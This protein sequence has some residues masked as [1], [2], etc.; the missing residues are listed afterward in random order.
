MKIIH[1]ADIHLSSKMTAFLTEK[2]ASERREEITGTFFNLVEFA[3]QNEVRAII[4]AG[5]FF[6]SADFVQSSTVKRINFIISSAPKID[7][8]YLRGN[9]DE[10]TTFLDEKNLPN[11]KTFSYKNWKKYSYQEKNQIVDI[12]GLETKTSIPDE[13]YNSLKP[14]KSHLNIAILHGQTASYRTKD[15]AAEISLP[16][17]QMKNLDYLAL[18]HI[19]EF[20]IEKLDNRATWCYSGCLEGRGFDECGKKGFVLLEIENHKISQKFIPFAKRTFHE[21]NAELSENMDYSKILNT[22]LQKISDF[23]KK[24]IIQINLTGEISEETQID[25]FSFQEHL[26]SLD[27]YFAKIKDKTS[28]K[29]E[30]QKY[31][32]ELSLKGEFIRLVKSQKNLDEKEKSEIILTGIKALKGI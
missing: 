27:F 14:E 2:K 22:I 6:D 8:L 15:T 21:I 29:I 13:F 32:N 25:L 30:F 20:K 5:D 19:H 4:I 28:K 18:G 12:Y 1:T 11:L 3:K 23:P 24:D 16:K 26:K 17:L 10:N 7:F 9:H 31:E